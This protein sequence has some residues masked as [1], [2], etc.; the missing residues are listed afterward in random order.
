MIMKIPNNGWCG[1]TST[2]IYVA[3]IQCNFWKGIWQ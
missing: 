1:K 2:A 3:Q